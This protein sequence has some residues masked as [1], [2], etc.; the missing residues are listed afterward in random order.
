M[1]MKI[2]SRSQYQVGEVNRY[3]TVTNNDGRKVGDVSEDGTVID[4]YGRHVGNVS[5]DGTITNDDDLKIGAVNEDGTV[6][7]NDHKVGEVDISDEGNLHFAGGA[8]LLLSAC[9][10]PTSIHTPAIP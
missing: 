10:P 2:Y 6:M 9:I 7:D 1:T 3:G 8:A 5:E 4:G